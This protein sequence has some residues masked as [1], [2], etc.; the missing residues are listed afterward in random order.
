MNV[1]ILVGANFM[2]LNNQKFSHSL[3]ETQNNIWVG[4]EKLFN[5]LVTTTNNTWYDLKDFLYYTNNSDKNILLSSMQDYIPKLNTS[6]ISPLGFYRNNFEPN[7]IKDIGDF[8]GVEETYS[9]LFRNIFSKF[10]SNVLSFKAGNINVKFTSYLTQL[11][12]ADAVVISSSYIILNQYLLD[13][14]INFANFL[15][16]NLLFGEKYSIEFKNSINSKIFTTEQF[17]ATHLKDNA[18]QE[19]L[20]FEHNIVNILDYY[21]Q[22]IA[23]FI[24]AV[25]LVPTFYNQYNKFNIQSPVI[26]SHLQLSFAIALLDS[27]YVYLTNNY[28]IK[29]EKDNMY[30][31]AIVNYNVGY[32]EYN[33]EKIT[34]CCWRRKFILK[35]FNERKVYFKFK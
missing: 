21:S 10:I 24:T 16:Y 18:Q 17:L 32:D 8:V 7:A 13:P 3:Y 35:N 15:S 27:A 33:I 25:S 22:N 11:Y 34:F 4:S 6:D 20:R 12:Q 30:K 9:Y 31:L 1:N 14:C 28:S 5:H 19:Y 29:T 23:T 26:K 2:S